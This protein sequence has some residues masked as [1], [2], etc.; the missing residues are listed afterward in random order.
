[1]DNIQ[2][3]ALQSFLHS[4]LKKSSSSLDFTDELTPFVKKLKYTNG[5]IDPHIYNISYKIRNQV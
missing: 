5:E 2:N 1:M 4:Y 3:F